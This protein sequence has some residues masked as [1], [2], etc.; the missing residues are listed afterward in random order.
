MLAAAGN[1]RRLLSTCVITAAVGSPSATP[2]PTA[3]MISLLRRALASSSP[4]AAARWRRSLLA[5]LLSPP[6]GPPGP[7]RRAPA[8]PRRA[9]HGSP[10]PLGFRST[11]AS[12][13]GP[14]EG[15]GVDKGEEGLEIAK[16]GISA[17][18]VE[19]LAARGI[20]RLFPFRCRLSCVNWMIQLHLA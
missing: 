7:T 18:I 17:R 13:A 2:L 14:G 4:P 10:C 20:A 8:P 1:S 3:A 16:L 5:A 9:F 6:A 12:W 15:V 19:R 11:L